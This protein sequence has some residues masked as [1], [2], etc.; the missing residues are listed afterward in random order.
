MTVEMTQESS[1]DKQQG[2]IEKD[3]MSRL[4]APIIATLIASLVATYATY[5]YNERQMELARIEA[6]DKYRSYI[7]SPDP[8]TREYGFFVFEE[9][10]YRELVNKLAVSREDPAALGVLLS[11]SE[12]DS[13]VDEINQAVQIADNIMRKASSPE[14]S[15]VPSPKSTQ[16]IGESKT[17]WVY[18]GHFVAEK[19]H[20]KTRYLNFSNNASP[21]DLVG[22]TYEVRK[23]TGALNVRKDMPGIFGQ[24]RDIQDVLDVGGGVEVLEYSEWQSSGYIWAKIRYGA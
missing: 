15:T 7:N 23:E 4:L 19:G 16:D 20:W 21:S 8:A 6:L 17:G 12:N 14:Q 2:F 1:E 11:R 5:T 3:S 24:F 18:L 22:K 10:G 9:F 13:D